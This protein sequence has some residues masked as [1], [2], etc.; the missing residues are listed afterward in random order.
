MTT[1]MS[2]TITTWATVVMAIAAAFSMVTTIVLAIITNRYARETQIM[3]KQNDNLARI[4]SDQLEEQRNQLRVQQKQ[5]DVLLTP[6]L[7]VVVMGNPDT[8]HL[9]NLSNS[10]C[11]VIEFKYK[12]AERLYFLYPKVPGAHSKQST[13][14]LKP[15]EAIKIDLGAGSP[16]LRSNASYEVRSVFGPTGDREWS[17]ILTEHR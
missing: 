1:E 15:G 6:S 11:H 13:A 9:L 14:L 16:G 2:L 12:D 4:Q 8:L 7:Q 3:R 10:Y 17:Q 5:L